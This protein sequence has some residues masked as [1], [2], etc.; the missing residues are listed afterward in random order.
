MRKEADGGFVYLASPYTRL[1]DTLGLDEAARIVALAAGCLMDEGCVVFSPIAHGHA[2]ATAFDF[3]KKD[4]GF[5]MAQC[6][7]VAYAANVCVVLKM[8]GWQESS[9]VK[10]E[11]DFFKAHGKPV[12][13]VEPSELIPPHKL[14]NLD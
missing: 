3:D 9:G 1:A 4:Q 7:P 2:V 13:Y 14:A 11:V 5:W 10:A 8:D 6:Y 12:I